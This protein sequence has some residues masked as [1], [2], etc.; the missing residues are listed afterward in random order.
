MG[1]GGGFDEEGGV[2]LGGVYA[3]AGAG[4]CK[5]GELFGG[6]GVV[7]FVFIVGST[8]S[9]LFR[10]MSQK[11]GSAVPCPATSRT[12]ATVD[13]FTASRAA[14]FVFHYGGNRSAWDAEFWSNDASSSRDASPTTSWSAA[15]VFASDGHITRFNTGRLSYLGSDIIFSFNL[16]LRP[17]APSASPASGLNSSPLLY[18]RCR[19]R[20][21]Y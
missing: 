20:S 12:A 14:S 6:G 4:Y 1:S 2:G 3:A 7:R 8:F 18:R 17:P 21:S 13:C 5:G 16:N 9:F 10:N 11:A 19:R 15:L